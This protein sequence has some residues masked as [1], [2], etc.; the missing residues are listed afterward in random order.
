MKLIIAAAVAA[1]SFIPA[2]FAQEAATNPFAA[3]RGYINEPETVM[4]NQTYL[5]TTISPLLEGYKSSAL[6]L[7]NIPSINGFIASLPYENKVAVRYAFYQL[8]QSPT[9]ITPEM[10]S[11]YFGITGF[12]NPE[13]AKNERTNWQKGLELLADPDYNRSRMAFLAKFCDQVGA[14][15]EQEL[16]NASCAGFGSS[17]TIYNAYELGVAAGTW[18]Q[19][20]QVL[21][22]ALDIVEKTQDADAAA[23]AVSE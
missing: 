18:P 6:E 7:G 21:E 20:A 10:V 3:A 17:R 14:S 15:T 8:V 2:A 9:K 19:F 11:L 5:Y 16:R 23:A 13:N 1:L 22:R 4:N 12:I